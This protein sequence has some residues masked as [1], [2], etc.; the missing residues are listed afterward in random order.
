MRHIF[1]R[2]SIQWKV[3][4]L[5]VSTATMV[6]MLSSI[7]F[8][9]WTWRYYSR[10]MRNHTESLTTVVGYNSRAALAFEDRIV[11]DRIAR[12]VGTEAHILAVMI[13][14]RE[15]R[16]FAANLDPECPLRPEELTAMRHEGILK[17]RGAFIGRRLILLNGDEVGSV[18]VVHTLRPLYRHAVHT[19]AVILILFAIS[20]LAALLIT[21]HMQQLIT[22]PLLRLTA[23]IQRVSQ[24]KDYT[25]Q[26]ALKDCHDEVGD[27]IKGFNVMIS[28]LARHERELRASEARYRL[29]AQNVTDIISCHQ[30]TTE[31]ILC[32]YI[33]PSCRKILGF[34]PEEL[35]GT[36]LNDY[37]HPEDIP[38]TNQQLQR[39]RK[40]PQST[41]KVRLRLRC[42]NGCY[43]WIESSVGMMNTVISKQNSDLIVVS[44][45]I[46][47]Q[48]NAEQQLLHHQAQLQ[49]MATE[50]L[51]V[52]EKERQQLAEDLHDSLAQTLAILKIR[53]DTLAHR[54]QDLGLVRELQSIASL[55]ETSIEQ[56][57]NL[58]FDLSPPALHS[59]GLIQAVD[60]LV[61]RYQSMYDLE[62]RLHKYKNTHMLNLPENLAIL[63]FRAIRE[64]LVNIVKHAAA[65]SASI[66]IS[67]DNGDLQIRVEDDGCGFPLKQ[68]EQNGHKGF[69]LFSLRE[70]IHNLGGELKIVT[71]P[72]Q[73]TTVSIH[74]DLLQIQHET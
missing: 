58:T 64:L 10:E 46:T 32:D 48:V 50:I 20:M 60:G 73:G 14:D 19:A 29:L 62:I 7:G 21:R 67:H 24:N 51:L 2:L 30:I 26:V 70:R 11:A 18:V 71:A 47:T 6:L 68:L 5:A 44:R 38:P 69:G 15:H 28:S 52:E 56:A 22:Q 12:S 17:T 61:E 1:Q 16:L 74:I 63:L 66:H 59:L 42:K 41:L 43:T 3:F 54:C 34:G 37:V 25:V 13:Y 33:S 27:L 72:G 55:L 36:Y 53:A 31:G 40:T 23:A 65:S 57:R 4:W 49:K 45:D 35:I 39:L 8:M 9:A